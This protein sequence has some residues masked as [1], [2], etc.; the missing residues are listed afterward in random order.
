MFGNCAGES[1]GAARAAALNGKCPQ[2]K[3]TIAAAKS[4]GA[5]SPAL[6]NSLNGSSCK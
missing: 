5:D 6:N 1:S 4:M 3:G 2:A